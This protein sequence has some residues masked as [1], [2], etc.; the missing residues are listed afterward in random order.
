MYADPI[1]ARAFIRRQ[2]GEYLLL[3]VT[4]MTAKQ[5]ER[6]E[7]GEV[8]GEDRKRLAVIMLDAASRFDGPPPHQRSGRMRRLNLSSGEVEQSVRVA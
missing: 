2:L 4:T 1:D 7:R 5:R 6:I 3:G 8:I